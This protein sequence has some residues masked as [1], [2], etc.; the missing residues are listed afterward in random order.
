MSSP[1]LFNRLSTR[2]HTPPLRD[3][4]VRDVVSM[5]NCAMR[6]ASFGVSSDTPVASSVLNFGNPC[7]ATLGIS[8]VDPQQ[9]ATSIRQTLGTFEPRLL[10]AR[11]TVMARQD[12]DS[13][14]SRILYFDVHGVLKLN[15]NSI[16]IRLMLDYLGCFF[17][18]VQERT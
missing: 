8:R 13:P 9:I 15:H 6:G 3:C 5:L 14:G 10:A 16:T 2:A 7:M 1:Q 11:T 18:S 12:T 17:S 4:V